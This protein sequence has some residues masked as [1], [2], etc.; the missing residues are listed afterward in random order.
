MPITS[1]APR[2]PVKKYPYRAI[3]A[4]SALDRAQDYL[5]YRLLLWFGVPFSALIAFMTELWRSFR[6][7]PPNPRLAFGVFVVSSAICAWPLYR[8]IKRMRPMIQGIRGE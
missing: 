1:A 8:L 2:D 3:P 7:A 4:E 6:P 5:F